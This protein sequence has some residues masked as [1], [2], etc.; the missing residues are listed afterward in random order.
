MDYN[1]DEETEA[2]RGHPVSKWQT[3]ELNLSLSVLKYLTYPTYIL[4]KGIY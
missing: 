4:I 1:I 2:Q 3:W